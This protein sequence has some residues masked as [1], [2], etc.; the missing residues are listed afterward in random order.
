MVIC[1]KNILEVTN[2]N[3][4]YEGNRIL[5]NISFFVEQGEF[6]AIMGQSGCGKSTLLYC[7]SRMDEADSGSILFGGEELKAAKEQKMEDIRLH[8]MG[9]VFQKPN[10]VKNLSVLDNI[11]FPGFEAKEKTRKEVVKK[12]K[13]LTDKTG[14]ATVEANDIR[15]VSGGQLQRAAIC[16]ALIN[17][18]EIIFA[19]EPTGAL[20]SSM[21]KEIMDIFNAVH[22]DGTAILLV[23]HDAK[24][25]ARA[26]RVIFLEDGAIKDTMA[27]GRYDAKFCEEREQK[28]KV[29]LERLG[30]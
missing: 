2:L 17:E 22:E 29:W 19:D 13:A 8:R 26:D 28:M 20:N 23:T 6:I 3:K 27:L 16:R 9:F 4:E 15:Q 30:F 14:I 12:A 21:T 5:R 24:V 18:P 10:L 25:A 11:V 7:A 1:M